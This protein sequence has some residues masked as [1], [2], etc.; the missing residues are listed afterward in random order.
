MKLFPLLEGYRGRPKAD[1]AAAI[2]AVVKIADFALAHA[3]ELEELDINP[4]IVCRQGEGAWIADALVVC[5]SL[6]PVHGEKVS[7]KAT[8]A[9]R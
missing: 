1:L 5:S 9:G 4:L 7:P 8:D 3:D 6:L 2:D